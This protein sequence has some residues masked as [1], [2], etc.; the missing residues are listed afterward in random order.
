MDAKLT[1]SLNKAIIEKAKEYSKANKISLSRLIEHY[2]ASLVT[3]NEKKAE[4]TP[5]VESL[6]GVM[7]MPEDYSLKDDYADFLIKKYK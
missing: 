4:I 6:G 7:E 5:L 1:L 2:L 3:K